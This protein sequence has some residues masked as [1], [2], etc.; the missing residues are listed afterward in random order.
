MHNESSKSQVVSVT[1]D[2]GCS[3]HTMARMVGMKARK[4]GA[5][6][7]DVT[8]PTGKVLMSMIAKSRP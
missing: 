7:F 3:R 8:S 5:L 4:T 6:P 1:V 2:G